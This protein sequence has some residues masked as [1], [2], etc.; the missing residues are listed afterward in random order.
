MN[1]QSCCA[2]DIKDLITLDDV[3]EELNYGPNG[4]LVYCMEF[5]TNN[6]DWLEEELGN[7]ENDYLIFDLPGQ[8][9]LYTHFPVM[10]NIK[11]FLSKLG[12]S[13]CAVYLIDSQFVEDSEAPQIH[14]P[15]P[16]GNLTNSFSLMQ[17]PSSSRECWA[18]CPRWCSWNFLI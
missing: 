8:I 14:F 1:T 5:L 13:M 18:H 4:G 11:D 9:E 2:I 10:K 7:F 15:P 12:Y 6:L 17:L 16:T 3:A